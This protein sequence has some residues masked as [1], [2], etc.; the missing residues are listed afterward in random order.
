MTQEKN[1]IKGKIHKLPTEVLKK[2]G[3]PIT[4]KYEFRI[5]KNENMDYPSVIPFSL[6][7]RGYENF[8]DVKIGDAV[9][10]DF[11][12]S[13]REWQDRCF[14]EIIAWKVSVDELQKAVDKD[15]EISSDDIDNLPF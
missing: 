9:E 13:G 15:K 10:I 3:T 11:S 6:V 4:N 5:I 8:P 2:D 14:G 7:G 12:L 1:I